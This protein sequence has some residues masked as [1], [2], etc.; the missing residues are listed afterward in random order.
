ML[1]VSVRYLPDWLPGMEFKQTAQNWRTTLID[2]VERPYALGKQ[3]IGHGMGRLSYLSFLLEGGDL[4]PGSEEEFVAKWSAMSI[5]GGGADTVSMTLTMRSIFPLQET[6][7][8]VFSLT[9]DPDCIFNGEFL[10]GY[11]IVP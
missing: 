9:T 7:F 6:L 5:Y 2:L 10:P 4:K 3:R 11:D 8:S 1:I